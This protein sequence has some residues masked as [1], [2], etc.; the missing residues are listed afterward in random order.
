MLLTANETPK[1]GIYYIPVSDTERSYDKNRTRK[2]A[3]FLSWLCQGTRVCMWL[4][5]LDTVAHLSIPC[6][7]WSR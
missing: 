3:V 7:S 6:A 5:K 4:C 2:D 1:M